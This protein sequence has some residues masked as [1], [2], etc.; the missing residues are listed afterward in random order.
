MRGGRRRSVD[1]LLGGA[2][3]VNPSVATRK[4]LP[5]H[6]YRTKTKRLAPLAEQNCGGGTQP[7]ACTVTRGDAALL[8]PEKYLVS[9]MAD[10]SR[11]QTIQ[12]RCVQCREPIGGMPGPGG[13]N[14]LCS[15]CVASAM[16]VEEEPT[17]SR[18]GVPCCCG[19]NCKLPGLLLDPSTCQHR[20]VQCSAPIHGL[21]GAPE[22]GN[23]LQ[24]RCTGCMPG[25]TLGDEQPATRQQWQHCPQFARS[26]CWSWASYQAHSSLVE[27][28]R[29]EQMSW[30]I[31][32]G[33]EPR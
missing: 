3:P 19:E 26:H 5:P 9:P 31:L 14:E 1:S 27:A 30:S 11:L 15:G 20:C 6:Q 18:L 7:E 2:A 32:R 29:R 10:P 25:G 22:G 24:R 8:S 33:C 13:G 23:E 21:C 16:E 28:S 12:H 4:Q 17:A